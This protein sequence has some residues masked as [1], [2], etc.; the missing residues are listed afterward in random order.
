[1]TRDYNV[2]PPL[3]HCGFDPDGVGIRNGKYFGMPF[4]PEQSALVLVSVPWD[5]TSSYGGGS[6][7]APSA[8]IEESVQ[9]DFYDP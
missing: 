7:A 8:I 4:D 2:S 6:S 3:P 9:L 5:V 1:M